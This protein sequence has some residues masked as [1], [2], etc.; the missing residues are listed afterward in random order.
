MLSMGHEINWLAHYEGL[1]VV[2]NG[3]KLYKI[4]VSV[5]I[6]TR[7]IK[8]TQPT[9]CRRQSQGREFA[10]GTTSKQGGNCHVYLLDA[11]VFAFLLTD[12]TMRY[13][14]HASVA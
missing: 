1:K 13:L 9:D 11:L 2:L 5:L 4:P 6:Y 8:L 12:H 7:L 3:W 14:M 10:V